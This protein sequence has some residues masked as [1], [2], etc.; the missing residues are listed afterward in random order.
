MG[1]KGGFG[2]FFRAFLAPIFIMLPINIIGCRTPGPDVKVYLSNPDIGGMVR[3]R[4]TEII[5]YPASKG[6]MCMNPSDFEA[7]LNY[8]LN[9]PDQPTSP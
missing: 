6:F 4:G 7:L 9:P 5:T 2:L 3:N 1:S 8:C